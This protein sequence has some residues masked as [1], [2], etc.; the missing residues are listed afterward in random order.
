MWCSCACK[1]L[2][3]A[4]P[5]SNKTPHQGPRGLNQTLGTRVLD[6]VEENY[7]KADINFTRLREGKKLVSIAHAEKIMSI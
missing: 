7:L 5:P 2:N 4:K 3:S 6:I 1:P